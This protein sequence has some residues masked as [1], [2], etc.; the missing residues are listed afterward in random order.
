MRLSATVTL[1][2]RKNPPDAAILILIKSTSKRR[3][4]DGVLLLDKPQGITSNAALQ[5]VKRI[6]NAEKAGHVGT[7]DPMATGLLPVCLGEAT[8]FSTDL[9]NAD[10]TYE[11]EVLLG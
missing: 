7:L 8:K 11:A 3:T 10:K 1:P 4:V 6:Y 9:F 2:A 5:R